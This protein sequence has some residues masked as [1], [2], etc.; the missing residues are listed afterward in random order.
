MPTQI[1]TLPNGPFKVD[2][3]IELRD[4]EGNVF[5]T[6]ETAYLCR[7]GHSAGKPFCDGAHAKQGFQAN[8][9]AS[10]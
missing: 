8:E 6:K 4:A 1:T 2:G 7:C 9:L 3:L 10:K 5:T